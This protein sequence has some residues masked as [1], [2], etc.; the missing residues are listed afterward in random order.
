[1]KIKKS[2]SNEFKNKNFYPEYFEK[3][4]FCKEFLGKLDKSCK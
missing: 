3:F 2:S 4:E 1:M